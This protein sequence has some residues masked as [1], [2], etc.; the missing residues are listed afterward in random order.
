M[1]PLVKM[2]LN[3]KRK[4]TPSR[5]NHFLDECLK[6][7]CVK[8]QNQ[9]DWKTLLKSSSP[10]FDPTPSCEQTT[11][12]ERHVQAFLKTP[13]GTVTPPPPWAVRSSV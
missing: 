12:L 13:P 3:K 7:S 4:K 8:S 1:S 2:R 10:T 11:A 6:L 5:L 9:L